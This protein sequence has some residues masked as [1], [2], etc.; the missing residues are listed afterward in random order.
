MLPDLT[1]P[2]VA[3]TFSQTFASEVNTTHVIFI[4]HIRTLSIMHKTFSVFLKKKN[5]L[6]VMKRPTEAT[7]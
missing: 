5:I 7:G 3:L 2:Q 1:I 4:Q 6:N